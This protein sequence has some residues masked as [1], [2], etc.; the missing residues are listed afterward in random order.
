VLSLEISKISG[1]VDCFDGSQA[2]FK[3][4]QQIKITMPYMSILKSSAP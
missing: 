4:H 1:V 3:P 2:Y